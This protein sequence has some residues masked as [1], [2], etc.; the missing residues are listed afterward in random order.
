MLGDFVHCFDCYAND[1]ELSLPK[2]FIGTFMA[3]I[4]HRTMK[5]TTHRHHACEYRPG[6]A[7]ATAVTWNLS[8]LGLILFFFL[9]FSS[10]RSCVMKQMLRYNKWIEW[11]IGTR[12]TALIKTGV[13]RINNVAESRSMPHIAATSLTLCVCV[14]VS[15]GPNDA[16]EWQLWAMRSA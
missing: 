8:C 12:A 13:R 10:Q 7:T 5:S 1:G 14:C 3:R 6:T 15:S 2:V 4:Y 16:D 11:W 9:L